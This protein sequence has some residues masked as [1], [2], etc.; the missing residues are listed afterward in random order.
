MVN[1]ELGDPWRK[2]AVYSSCHYRVLPE[3]GRTTLHVTTNTI[4]ENVKNF[5]NSSHPNKLL[6]PVVQKPQDKSV[7]AAFTFSV[8]LG[9]RLST[10]QRFI[11]CFAS[12]WTTDKP[13]TTWQINWT[14]FTV[15]I[16]RKHWPEHSNFSPLKPTNKGTIRTF[17]TSRVEWTYINEGG[18]VWLSR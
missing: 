2:N 18:D 10:G 7:H 13:T 16:F 8:G 3:A 14:I 11:Q 15:G 9:K 5:M 17:S 4:S 6:A 1:V 12:S